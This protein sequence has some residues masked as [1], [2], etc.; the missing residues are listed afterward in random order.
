[1]TSRSPR[2][3]QQMPSTLRT[4]GHDV[5]VA[6][7]GDA[8]V[9]VTICSRCNNDQADLPYSAWARKLMLA[10]DR[11]AVFVAAVAEFIKGG[12][13]DH[14]NRRHVETA[15]VPSIE[16]QLCGNGDVLCDLLARRRFASG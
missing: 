7:G 9:W 10:G 5:A 15:Y 4:R 16:P 13:H 3:G 6:R 14:D 12:G 11:R 2:R 1:M 8:H